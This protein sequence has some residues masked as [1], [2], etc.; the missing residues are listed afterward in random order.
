MLCYECLVHGIYIRRF[1]HTCACMYVGICVYVHV[2]RYVC[3]RACMFAYVHMCMNVGMCVYV[4][5]CRH[6]Y[7]MDNRLSKPTHIHA[8]TTKITSNSK[9]KFDSHLYCTLYVK[10]VK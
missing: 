4:H 9:Y 5:A 6:E 7:S 2:C 10:Y 8:Y 3:I 1:T